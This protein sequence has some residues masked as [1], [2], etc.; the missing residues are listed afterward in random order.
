MAVLDW[1]P[2]THDMRGSGPL[3]ESMR[4]SGA[5]V[6][7]G[8]TSLTDMLSEHRESKK[9][10]NTER[11]FLDALAG[12]GDPQTMQSNFVAS[13]KRAAAEGEPVDIREGLSLAQAPISALQEQRMGA[14]EY[15]GQEIGNR[16]AEIEQSFL[17]QEKVADIEAKRVQ[18]AGALGREQREAVPFERSEENIA[19]ADEFTNAV[20]TFVAQAP[21]KYGRELEPEEIQQVA[22][23]L[24]QDP[25]WS[26]MSEAAWGITSFGEAEAS[27]KATEA[28]MIKKQH[29]TNEDIRKEKAKQEAKGREAFDALNVTG[30]DGIPRPKEGAKLIS[31]EAQVGDS[32]LWTAKDPETNEPLF[33]ANGDPILTNQLKKD[34]KTLPK[35]PEEMVP[36]ID[37][38]GAEVLQALDGNW[39]FED[40]NQRNK[41]YEERSDDY[42]NVAEL[43]FQYSNE[44]EPALVKQLFADTLRDHDYDVDDTLKYL[45]K[46][47]EDTLNEK[48]RETHIFKNFGGNP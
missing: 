29:E 26:D 15:A 44:L 24:R 5:G 39:F 35:K 19:A 17:P 8:I 47:R 25:S 14:A 40:K 48:R 43:M 10:E 30:P 45:R 23:K 20:R 31:A 28:E 42:R 6:S 13:L 36:H 2:V 16:T 46:N 33:D 22:E 21:E 12:G 41:P 11:H 4:Q 7:G 3:L 27:R 37:S 32:I 34:I 9:K 38:M 1:T 18:T